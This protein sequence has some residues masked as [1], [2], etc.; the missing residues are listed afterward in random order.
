MENAK[1]SG[2][3]RCRRTAGARVRRLLALL[4]LWRRTSDDTGL[5]IARTLVLSV[6]VGACAGL[7]AVALV[8]LLQFCNWVF[9][10]RIAHVA[11]G[12]AA[13]EPEALPLS[14]FG[15][16]SVR[17]WAL[18]LLG[19]FGGLLSGLL[20]WR[21]AP[22]AAGHGTDA[23]IEAYHFRG[24]RVRPVA[25]PVKALATSILIGTGGSAGC[26]GPITQ[27]GAGFGSMVSD[28]LRLPVSTRRKLMAAGMGAGVGALF[29]APLAGAIFAAELL[30]RDLDLEY[31]V[32]V[33]A[34]VASA[35]G[36][37]LYSKVFGFSPLFDMPQ[38]SFSR[39]HMLL[40]YLVLAVVLAF[41][42]R[43]YTWAFWS[44]H[45][46]F[47]RM[48]LPAWARPAV[49]GALVGCLGAAFLP[50]LGSGYGALQDILRLDSASRAAENFGCCGAASAAGAMLA[51]FF[52]KTLATALSVGSGGSG[53]IFGPAI[54]CGGT[55]GGA[56]GVAFGSLLP[57]WGVNVGSFALVGMVAFFGCAAKAPISM[58][59][60]ISEMTGNHRLLVPSMWVVIVAYLLTR[61]VSL[62]R[63]QLPNRFE[64]P[65]H[66]GDVVRGTLG[67]LT[68]GD[69]LQARRGGAQ[70]PAAVRTATAYTPLSSLA[71]MMSGGGSGV[72]PVVDGTG[73]LR[74]VVTRRDLAAVMDSDPM[75]RAA[76]L[77]GDL[78]LS[79]HPVVRAGDPLRDILAKMD[80]DDAEAIVVA[81]GPE[82]APRPAAVLT[83][84]DI[85]AAYQAEIAARR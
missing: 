67:C 5:G 13:H 84:N 7:G 44:A 82:D 1:K 60:M 26:E 72:V 70:R 74:G 28:L 20:A 4:R 66:R 32:L 48:K 49:G 76:L 2:A 56:V 19:G 61:K 54:V 51:F 68:A 47:S 75:L 6:V 71:E 25:V 73:S 21:F 45:E 11:L 37:T 50:A 40:L 80:A 36:Y 18:P 65:V 58:I 24:G 38:N 14:G 15:A 59:I 81:D 35:T 78:E 8:A 53:G 29:H 79:P 33:P 85:A 34:V 39:P 43:F 63:S 77:V 46:R 62:Y 31:E 16:A 9:L 17:R 41:G 3:R 30:Y 69:V 23:A 27:I 12:G 64:A 22:E 10:G 42:A 83:H 55:L 57:G 52:A